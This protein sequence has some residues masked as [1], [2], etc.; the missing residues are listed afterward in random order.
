MNYECIIYEK[1]ENVG[2]I[3]LNRP[4]FRNAMNRQ[5]WLD[6]L[7]ALETAKGDPDIRV[8]IFTGEEAE[9]IGL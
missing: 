4:R 3:K 6:M 9:R 1:K 5:L 7:D 2:L 8:L